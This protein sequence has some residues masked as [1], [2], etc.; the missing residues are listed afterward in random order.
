MVGNHSPQI[1]KGLLI[2][3]DPPTTTSLVPEV[4]TV[5]ATCSKERIRCHGAGVRGILRQE[6]RRVGP[7]P[8]AMRILLAMCTAAFFFAPILSIGGRGLPPKGFCSETYGSISSMR[9]CP[10]HTVVYG[11]AHSFQ[12]KR[13]FSML[14]SG[15]L[16]LTGWIGQA[17]WQCS[18]RCPGQPPQSRIFRTTIRLSLV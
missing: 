2:G 16:L 7:G 6:T 1:V 14:S 11:H 18:F 9:P 4:T 12:R 10:R 8:G 13:A 5:F 17:V 15:N 3:S